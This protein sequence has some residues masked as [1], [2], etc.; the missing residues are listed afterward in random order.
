MAN[1]K[2]IHGNFHVKGFSPDGDSIRF[3]ADKPEHWNFFK[4]NTLSKKKAL[5][6]QL[7]IEAID[8]LETHYEGYHQPRSFGVAALERMLGYLG[9]SGLKYSLSVAVIVEAADAS[10]GFI[11]SGGVDRY[12]RPVSFTFGE[13]AGL[14]DGAEVP[15]ENLPLE[16]SINYRLAKSGLVYPTFYT[17]TSPNVVERFRAAVAEARLANRGLWAIDRTPDFTLWDTRT[18][19]EDALILPKLFRR[20]V[21]FFDDR[22][23]LSEL[24]AYLKQKKDRLK[25][26]SGGPFTTLDQ[27]V[28]VEGRRV[29]LETPVEDMLFSPTG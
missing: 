4:W 10:P 28:K 12:D 6:K 29:R 24:P 19:Q 25:L 15:V 20:I 18:L 26:W 16:E 17:T 7:R 1:L 23:D 27:L 2:I 22:G 21:S 3:T 13:I 8:A 5:K 11:A 9:I 14:L